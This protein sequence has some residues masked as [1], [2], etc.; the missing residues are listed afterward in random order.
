MLRYAI[1]KL[2]DLANFEIE[3]YRVQY[4]ID[5]LSM[6]VPVNNVKGID[7]FY[8]EGIKY[9]GT[10]ASVYNWIKQYNRTLKH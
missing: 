9:P 7:S 1:P 2:E 6:P 8:L 4:T 5:P 10:N 3:A